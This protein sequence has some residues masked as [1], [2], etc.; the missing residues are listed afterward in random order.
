MTSLYL[1]KVKEMLKSMDDKIPVNTHTAGSRDHQFVTALAIWSV[2]FESGK[3]LTIG[4]IFSETE[5]W[6]DVIRDV[7]YR[8]QMSG[9]IQENGTLIQ[10]E[11]D[12]EKDDGE[13][14]ISYILWGLTGAGRLRVA[15]LIKEKRMI[16]QHQRL[17]HSRAFRKTKALKGI[18]RKQEIV[19]VSGTED[20][21]L[22]KLIHRKLINLSP[23]SDEALRQI[24]ADIKIFAP[25]VPRSQITKRLKK[26]NGFFIGEWEYRPQ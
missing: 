5:E 2:F 15:W 9:H 3:R 22:K 26:E 6:P 23:N 14:A 8:L 7:L 16:F 18:L 1:N 20:F 10:S 21:K 4:E 13:I 11:G 17:L 12:P 24:E 19:K 25:L